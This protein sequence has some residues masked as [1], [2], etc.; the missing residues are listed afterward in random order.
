MKVLM[1]QRHRE[2]E[3]KEIGDDLRDMQEV[4]E[5]YIEALYPFDDPVAIVCNEEGKIIGLPVNRFLFYRDTEYVDALCGNAF[6]CGQN[7]DDFT[8]IPAD[9]VDKY[10]AMFMPDIVKI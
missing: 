5:G 8:D 4:V 3:L 9:L 10:T 7:E 2:P 6:I 1:I